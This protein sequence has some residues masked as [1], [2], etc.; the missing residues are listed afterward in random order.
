MQLYSYNLLDRRNEL[1]EQKY[2][3]VKISTNKLVQ[4]LPSGNHYEL[5]VS[6]VEVC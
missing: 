3:Q 6:S 4:L 2:W 5:N 1:K